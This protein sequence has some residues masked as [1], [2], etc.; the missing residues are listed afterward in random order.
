[1]PIG[2]AAAV[3]VVA[4]VLAAASPRFLAFVREGSTTGWDAA[5]LKHYGLRDVRELDRAW[6][7]WHKVVASTSNAPSAI[8]VRAQNGSEP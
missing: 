6:R 3:L 8:L 1:M 7:A 2:A 5:T 4:L